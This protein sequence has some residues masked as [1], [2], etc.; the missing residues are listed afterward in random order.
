[1]KGGIKL[2][3]SLGLKLKLER[4]SRKIKAKE[5]ANY[6]GYTPSLISM[7]ENG[8]RS[9]DSDTYDKWIHYIRNFNN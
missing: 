5:I 1:M 4:I 7:V 2:G 9:V 3:D 6:L 8:K